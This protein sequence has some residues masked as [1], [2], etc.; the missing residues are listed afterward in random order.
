MKD[1]TKT[2][3]H[4]IIVQLQGENGKLREQLRESE[5]LADSAR[6]ELVAHREKAHGNYWGWQGDGEDHLESLSCPVLIPAQSLREIVEKL[7]ESEGK[8]AEM[9][10]LLQTDGC[11]DSRCDGHGTVCVTRMGDDG[12]PEPEPQQCQ[13]CDERKHALSTGCG[14]GWH[15]PDDWDALTAQC[16]QLR[17]ALEHIAHYPV[18]SEPMG[19][20]MDMQDI[21]EKAL[22]PTLTD[23]T[24]P[25]LT[26]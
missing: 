12:N 15:S 25:P 10:S 21:A 3:Q 8:C 11:I 14:K 24:F 18:H 7:R 13:W 2:A 20:A 17:E 22:N 5:A 23:P 26:P 16:H 4:D 9:R 6:R 1:P 19:G